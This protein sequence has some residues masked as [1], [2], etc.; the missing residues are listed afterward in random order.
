MRCVEP[1]ETS[2]S[3]IHAKNNHGIYYAPVLGAESEE[4]NTVGAVL[5][6][7]ELRV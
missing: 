5:P 1:K 7:G 6:L 2:R 4:V 3:P